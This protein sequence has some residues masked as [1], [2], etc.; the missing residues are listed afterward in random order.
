MNDLSIDE[1]KVR[2]FPKYDDHEALS[3]SILQ[4][5]KQCTDSFHEFLVTNKFFKGVSIFVEYDNALFGF[6]KQIDR[7][8]KF[9]NID[10]SNVILQWSSLCTIRTICLKFLRGL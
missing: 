9:G 10:S 7:C 6:Y 3:Y 4:N 5:A 2:Y 8:L 1:F